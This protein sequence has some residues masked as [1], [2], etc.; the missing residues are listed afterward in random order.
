[1][2][3]ELI[4]MGLKQKKKEKNPKWPTQKKFFNSS[5]QM[6]IGNY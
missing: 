3:A 4:F 2:K 6:E 5:N 1:M